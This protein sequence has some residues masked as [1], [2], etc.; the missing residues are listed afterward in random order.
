MP[1]IVAVTTATPPNLISQE[2]VKD[3]AQTHFGKN[4]LFQR[5]LPVFDNAMVEERHIAVDF[6][7]LSK[8]HS[9]TESNQRYVEVALNLSEQVTVDL[10]HRCAMPLDE[11]DVVFFISTTGLS[12]PSIDALLFNRIP[13]NPHIKRVPIWGLGCAGGAAGLSRAFEY[14]KAF[15]THRAL[16]IV[17]E[18]CS[19]SFQLEDPNKADIIS[20][21]LFGDGAAACA[22][23]GDDTPQ[24]EASGIEPTILGSLST[25]YPNTLDVMG[26]RATSEGFKV[27]LSQDIP[28]IVSSLVKSNIT[29]FL[30]H[31]E[32]SLRD[33]AHF[34]MHPGG[35]KVLQAYA[36]GLGAPIEKFRHCY[37]VLRSFGNMSSVT[38]YFIL[39]R[40][41]ED[42]SIL[43]G[44]FGLVGALGPGF[45]SELVLLQ[46]K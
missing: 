14:L 33:L 13:L 37:D 42:K 1:R 24:R 22:V 9:F 32:L 21:A 45:S 36:E 8:R 40:F 10:A 39:Q 17:V 38:V 4:K 41:L 28:T 5:L 19:L 35:V 23:F 12:T 18:L 31:Y 25:I 27:T 26:W 20:A 44:D 6:A 11:F 16:V 34:V 2:K 46:W 30:H 43:A 15:P 29:E 7:W 3:F